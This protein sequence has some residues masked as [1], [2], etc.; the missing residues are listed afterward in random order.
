[1]KKNKS[2]LMDF[3]ITFTVVF[4]V[5]MVIAFLYNLIVYGTSLI[6]GEAS[7]RLALTLAVSLAIIRQL[8]RN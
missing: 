5:G 2:V 3:V 1:M 7:F 8:K 4:V 6:D